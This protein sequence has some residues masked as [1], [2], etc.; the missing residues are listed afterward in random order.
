MWLL[1]WIALLGVGPSSEDAVTRTASSVTKVSS[2]RRAWLMPLLPMLFMLRRKRSLERCHT[3]S[4]CM[5]TVRLGGAWVV[6]GWCHTLA[7]DHSRG[8][9]GRTVGSLLKLVLGAQRS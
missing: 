9:L 4:S 7:I 5:Y 2:F 3:Q 6:H 1:L 8:P